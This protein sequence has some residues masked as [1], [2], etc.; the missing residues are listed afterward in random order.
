MLDLI[1]K[2]VRIQKNYFI[3]YLALIGFFVWENI[4]NATIVVAMSLAF[5][6]NT[7]YYDMK[8]QVNILLNSLPYTRK[9]IVS[10]KYVGTVLYTTG[11]VLLVYM[12]HLLI[13]GNISAFSLEN[14]LV[15]FGLVMLITSFSIPCSYIF[16]PQH[17]LMGGMILMAIYLLTF[18]LISEFFQESFRTFI[19]WL[20]KTPDV[21]LYLMGGIF[22]LILFGLS[23]LLSIGIYER[24]AF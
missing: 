24:K 10:S 4:P 22:V 16:K 8:D 14:I 11:V 19:N 17:V 18:K 7:L 13:N 12:G 9:E 2:D 20:M 6:M 15:G 5:I 23:W 3:F 21:Q 1:K